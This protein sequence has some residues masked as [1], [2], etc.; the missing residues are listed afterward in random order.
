MAIEHTG[1]EAAR[2]VVDAAGVTFPAIIDEQGAL[3]RRFGFKVV[4]NGVLV[5]EGGIIRWAKFGG[6]SIDN[7]DDIAVVERFLAGDE[8]GASPEADAPYALGPLEQ[9]LVATK[10][11]L[12]RVLLEAGRTPEAVATWRDAL[13]FDPANF[14]IRKQIW[15]AEYP[16]K[17]FPT[18]DF[19]WQ[20]KQLAAEREREMAE[21]IC[22]PDGYPL[23]WTSAAPGSAKA[24][25]VT[26]RDA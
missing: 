9:E 7:T 25:P 2:S 6:F 16:E 3:S 18:I 13:R 23:P 1:P 15:A 17:F 10:L 11:Q 12:G 22:G 21:G 20:Q 5:D 4:P 19:A 14:T 24:D 26:S 8:P